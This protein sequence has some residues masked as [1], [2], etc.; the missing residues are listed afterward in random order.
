MTA[1]VLSRSFFA[2]DPQVVAPELLNKLLIHNGVGGLIVEVEAYD[3]DSD[4]ASHAYRGRTPRNDVMFGPPGHLYVYFTYGMHYCCNTVCAEEGRATGILIR[5][6]EP[7]Q[8]IE[9]MRARR[10]KAGNGDHHLASGPGKICQALAI[11]RTHNGADLI[12]A[13]SGIQVLDA[14]VDPPAH[15][16]QGTRIGIR[17]GT[18]LPWRWWVSGNRNVSRR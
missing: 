12:S 18:E 13:D 16:A 10:P 2:R 9:T 8:G 14:G 3:G 17:A 11:D 5:A 4:P 1:E 7:V 6:I 15:P